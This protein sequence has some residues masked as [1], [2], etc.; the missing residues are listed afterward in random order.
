MATAKVHW[1]QWT[2]HI[3]ENILTNTKCPSSK[4][5]SVAAVLLVELI[6]FTW[7]FTDVNSYFPKNTRTTISVLIFR[8]PTTAKKLIL[9]RILTSSLTSLT[10]VFFDHWYWQI[11]GTKHDLLVHF[12]I[13]HKI[14]TG[15]WQILPSQFL[16]PISQNW[17]LRQ[18]TTSM[19]FVK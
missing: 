5:R 19:S 16:P 3:L 10:Y 2:E 6:T 9:I 14:A 11:L 8:S 13:L 15:K 7:S 12:K 18:H 1:K 17:L 4:Y